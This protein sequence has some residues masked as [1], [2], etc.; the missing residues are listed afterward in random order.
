MSRTAFSLRVAGRAD[1]D[2][3]SAVLASAYRALM[4]GD[5][6]PAV[7]AVTLPAM[8]AANPA[9][10][11]SGTYYVQEAAGGR[12]VSCGG[13]TREEPGTS[14]VENGLAHMRH[15]GTHAGWIRRGLGAGIFERCRQDALAAGVR[16]FRCFSTIGA[17]AFYASLGFRTAER[18]DLTIGGVVKLPVVIMVWTD[19][20]AIGSAA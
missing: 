18:V 7:L 5:E 10:L 20:P 6:G 9:L 14:R 17:E 16:T 4:A 2:A 15:F 19:S 1:A 12:I 11:A 3:V 13:W 8:T